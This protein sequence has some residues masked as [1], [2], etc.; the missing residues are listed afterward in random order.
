MGKLQISEPIYFIESKF[1]S[2]A[3]LR[4]TPLCSNAEALNRFQFF[5]PFCLWACMNK[6]DDNR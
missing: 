5:V 6:V 2:L 3:V 1:D 4:W